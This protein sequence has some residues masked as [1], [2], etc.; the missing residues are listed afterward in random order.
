[1][2]AGQTGFGKS[3]L[4]NYLSWWGALTGSYVFILDPKGDRKIGKKVYQVYRL[5]TLEYGL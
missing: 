3:V 4:M 2:V 5:N 1:M